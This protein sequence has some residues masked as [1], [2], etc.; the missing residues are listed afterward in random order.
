MI[1]SEKKNIYCECFIYLK[2]L[3]NTVFKYYLNTLK[4]TNS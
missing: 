1:Y 4:I 3:K 2:L